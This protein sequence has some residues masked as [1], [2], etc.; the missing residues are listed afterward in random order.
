MQFALAALTKIGAGLGISTATAGA[1]LNL[2]AAAGG[3]TAAA[4][5]MGSLFGSI[6]QG[7]ATVAGAMSALRAGRAESASLLQ[8]ASDAEADAV[9]E[10]ITGSERRNSLRAALLENIGERDVAYAA[11]GVDMSFGTPAEA[12]RAAVRDAERSMSMDLYTEQSRSARLRERAANLRRAARESRRG[13][14][15][16]ALGIGAS[17]AADILERG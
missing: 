12:R 11:S 14:F 13:G 15:L 2:A 3:G 1:P 9:T 10:Q 17:G 8:Q 5:G 16:R 6:L 7:T 4:G